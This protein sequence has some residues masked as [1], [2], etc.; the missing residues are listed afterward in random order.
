[1]QPV[2]ARR[3]NTTRIVLLVVGGVLALCCM[4]GVGAFA[5]FRSVQGATGPVRDAATAFIADLASGYYEHAYGQL[6]AD[7]RTRF[8]PEQFRQGVQARGAIR[9]YSITNVSVFNRNG[10]ATTGTVT[11]NLRY[12]SGFTDRHSFPLVKEDGAWRVCGQ[13]Y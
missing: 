5:L 11:A 6:C 9:G 8:T 13:P 3:R 12:D 10:R 1:M 2:P 4:G 7:T